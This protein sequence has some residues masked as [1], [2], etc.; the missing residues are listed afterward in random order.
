MLKNNL[1]EIIVGGIVISVLGGIIAGGI[2]VV[3][4][5]LWG[6][7]LK[8]TIKSDVSGI[9]R[10]VGV[11]SYAGDKIAEYEGK[12]SVD[13]GQGG[14]ISITLADGKKI[15]TSNVSVIVTDK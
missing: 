2:W 10:E 9:E 6:T 5:T 15:I 12:I 14:T 4:N 11:Y 8:N 7:K 13:D 3:N 1:Y